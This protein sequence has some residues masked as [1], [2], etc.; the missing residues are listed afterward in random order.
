MKKPKNY[1]AHLLLGLLLF[2][3]VTS[4]PGCYSE[5]KPKPANKILHAMSDDR[6][7]MSIIFIKD[8]DTFAVDY[9]TPKE[10][11]SFILDLQKK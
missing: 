10:V 6:G 4:Y 7:L 3:I 8:G 9:L 11:D 1:A 2:A 5:T